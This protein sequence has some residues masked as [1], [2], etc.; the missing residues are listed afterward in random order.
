[1]QPERLILCVVAP[2]LA[3]IDRSLNVIILVSFFTVLG[4][5]P[6]VMVALGIVISEA[7]WAREEKL[8][9]RTIQHMEADTHAQ[10]QFVNLPE[11]Y[12]TNDERLR[13]AQQAEALRE[14]QANKE[15]R[16]RP[17]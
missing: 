9:Q 6:G 1:M 12:H 4:W 7:Y 16:S 10:Q 2:P 15:T 14:Q 3:V 17:R 8:R 5:V 13:L 11:A